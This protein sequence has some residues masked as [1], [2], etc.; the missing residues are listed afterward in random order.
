M[1]VELMSKY[2]TDHNVEKKYQRR[3]SLVIYHFQCTQCY[4]EEYTGGTNTGHFNSHVLLQNSSAHML[5]ASFVV[6]PF[7]CCNF[8]YFQVNKYNLGP[9]FFFSF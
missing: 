9:L 7:T 1:F 6:F 8:G 4:G 3:D 5:V 2:K